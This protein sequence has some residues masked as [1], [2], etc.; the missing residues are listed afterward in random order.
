ML[1]DCQNNP[2]VYY[3]FLSQ[4]SILFT[5]SLACSSHLVLFFLGLLPTDPLLAHDDASMKLQ[6][7]PRL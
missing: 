6:T 1:S 4:S 5:Y 7:Y 3:L 2:Y